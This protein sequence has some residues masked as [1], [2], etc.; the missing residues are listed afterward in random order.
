[1]NVSKKAVTLKELP[2]KRKLRKGRGTFKTREEK[3]KTMSKLYFTSYL[4]EKFSAAD[5]LIRRKNYL[6]N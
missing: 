6:M 2:S 3:S 1:M 5:K 4:L